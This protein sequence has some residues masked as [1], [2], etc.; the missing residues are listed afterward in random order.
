MSLASVEELLP[1][2][3]AVLRQGLPVETAH[4]EGDDHP[5]TLHLKALDPQGEITGILTLVREAEVEFGLT[6]GYRLRGM[7][8]SPNAQGKGIGSL[9]LKRGLKEAWVRGFPHVWC[10]AREAAAPFYT[11]HGFTILKGPY[12]IPTAGPHF[13]L[14]ID[15]N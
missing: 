2:R 12:D 7:A 6:G 8:V 4:F 1:L 15:L 9:L 14:K 3:H 5:E 13:L 11:K 10:H